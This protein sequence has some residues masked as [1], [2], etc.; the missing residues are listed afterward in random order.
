MK[1]ILRILL[2][3]ILVSFSACDAN[4]QVASYADRGRS[5]EI[6]RSGEEK[7]PLKLVVEVATDGTLSLNRIKTGSMENTTHLRDSIEA[8]FEDRMRNGIAAREVIV[9]LNGDVGKD[10]LDNL[11]DA[12]ESVNVGPLRIV[13]NARE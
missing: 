3:A 10:D 9:V 4:R 6:H 8:I 7:D 13:T 1:E 5:E 2:I 12:L 11:I